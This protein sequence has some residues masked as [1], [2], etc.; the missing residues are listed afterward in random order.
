[1]ESAAAYLKAWANG[2][3]MVGSQPKGCCV[4]GGALDFLKVADLAGLSDRYEP[5][6]SSPSVVVVADAVADAVVVV[7]AAAA[8]VVVV[9]ADAAALEQLAA[10]IAHTLRAAA[11]GSGSG[12]AEIEH[13]DSAA[14]LV[15]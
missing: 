9:V 2:M 1:M 6:S 4:V 14:V 13:S 11:F 10:G 15:H 7:V 5:D 8:V 12:S 3:L